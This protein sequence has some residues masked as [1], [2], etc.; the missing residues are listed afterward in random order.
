MA[1]KF[2]WSRW[3]AIRSSPPPICSS[4]FN[5]KD[6]VAEKKSKKE[7]LNLDVRNILAERLH[8]EH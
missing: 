2:N 8:T 3:V 5:V 7:K 6:G 4:S 1:R